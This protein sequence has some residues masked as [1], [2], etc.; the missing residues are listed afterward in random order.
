MVELS[1]IEQKQINGGT[2][3]VRAYD[4]FGNL[5]IGPV[6]CTNENERDQTIAY[7]KSR[8]ASRI[9]VQNKFA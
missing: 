6:Y 9:T 3:I 8:A 1:L 7:C 5:F 4:V 2:Y